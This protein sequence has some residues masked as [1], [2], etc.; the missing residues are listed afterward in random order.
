[1]TSFMKDPA[2][3]KIAHFI[4]YKNNI[5][6]NSTRQV[7]FSM[8]FLTVFVLLTIKLS[9]NTA[10]LTLSDVL[11]YIKRALSRKQRHTTIFGLL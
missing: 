3:N 6:N 8:A 5:T 1:M 10:K 2:S 4:V 9:G 7:T 11:N